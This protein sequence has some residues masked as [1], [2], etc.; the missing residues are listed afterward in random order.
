MKKIILL[1]S[2]AEKKNFNIYLILIRMTS[3]ESPKCILQRALA[4]F[5]SFLSRGTEVSRQGAEVFFFQKGW[6]GPK[7]LGRSCRAEV[8]GAEVS[9][10]DPIYPLV[11]RAC[12]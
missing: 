10:P 12:I 1:H 2:H 5:A 7:W 4:S 11:F 3:A 8:V 6:K 9:K